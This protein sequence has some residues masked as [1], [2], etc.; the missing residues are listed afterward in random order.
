MAASVTMQSHS[1]CAGFRLLPTPYGFRNLRSVRSE[2]AFRQIRD[3]QARYLD[4]E[5]VRQ[6]YWGLQPVSG[7]DRP[8]PR[9]TKV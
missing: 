2:V 5:Q 3:G 9:R 8:V 6:D 7:A 4:N 1:S